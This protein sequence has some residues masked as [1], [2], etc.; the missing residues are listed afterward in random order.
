M[1][2]IG[3]LYK[4]FRESSGVTTDSRTIKG[5]EMFF[6]LKG[7]N[8]DG[9]E[10]ALKALDAGAAYA[11]VDEGTPVSQ[12]RDERIVP[13]GN[14]LKALKELAAF[15]RNSVT[16]DG[17]RLTVIGLTGTNGKT[18]TK[19]L[20]RSVL[21]V[22]YNVTAT[23]GNLNNEIGVPLSVLKINDET[24]L[25]VIEMGASH[26][27]DISSLVEVSQPDF[28]IITN[29]GKGH[30]LG[31][32]SLEGVRKTKGELYD[33]ISR[34]GGSVFLNEDLSYL[35][36]MA[37]E[38]GI[39]NVIPYGVKYD[40]ASVLPMTADCPC[41]SMKI[42]LNCTSSLSLHTHLV[43]AYNADNVMTSI[44]VGRH[45]GVPVDEAL[46]AIESYIPANSRSQMQK[47]ESNTLIVDA[48]NANP[49]SM[50]AA[51]RSLDALVAEH[52]IAMLGDMLELGADSVAEHKAI[53]YCVSEMN[54][55]KVFLVGEE[56]RKALDSCG[57][58]CERISWFADSAS[59]AEHLSKERLSGCTV[60]IKGSRG[61]RMERVSSSL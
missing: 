18:T 12:I 57:N 55:D 8:F 52:K 28:G 14:T 39:E 56:F 54:L 25:A 23:E 30:L 21:S 31:F 47:T 4:M 22:K 43:G 35:R 59:L 9:N 46:K 20:I 29:V 17:K 58:E 7:E 48:Y 27:G 40:G 24:Q 11:V 60:L 2:I 26:P 38:R 45:F 16:V 15:H 1:D 44:A 5:G 49:V 19:E 61:V 33:Y 36:E 13:V 51:L 41:L 34:T 42:P 32:G 50:K 3:K 6:A 53:V 37:Q 10:Y